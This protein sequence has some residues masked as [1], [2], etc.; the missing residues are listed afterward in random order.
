[1][2]LTFTCLYEGRRAWAGTILVYVAAVSRQHP[3]RWPC[4][5]PVYNIQVTRCSPLQCFN[6]HVSHQ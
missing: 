4:C 3:V 2:G 6:L 5:Q 1:M